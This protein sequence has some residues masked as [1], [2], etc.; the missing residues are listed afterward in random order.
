MHPTEVLWREEA[1]GKQ[2]SNVPGTTD[3]RLIAVLKYDEKD[4]RTLMEKVGGES[5]E[6]DAGNVNVEPWFPEAV[7]KFAQKDDDGMILEGATY[8]A[9]SYYRALFERQTRPRRT[10]KL[11]CPQDFLIQRNPLLP[12][13]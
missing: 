2:N 4:V 8:A 13:P 11:H 10:D 6:T 1:P 9:D 7:K 12:L 5:K 3:H